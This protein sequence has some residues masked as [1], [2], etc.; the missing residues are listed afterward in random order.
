[1][2]DGKVLSLQDFFAVTIFNIQQKETTQCVVS[3]D[4]CFLQCS[5]K[6]CRRR[7]D[8]FRRNRKQ[9]LIERFIILLLVGCHFE[10]TV[11][12]ISK[13]SSQGVG[14]NTANHSA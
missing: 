9:E 6:F 5:L 2:F 12:Q 10:N 1:M 14:R 3:I 4:I 7:N 8:I 13:Q 11:V